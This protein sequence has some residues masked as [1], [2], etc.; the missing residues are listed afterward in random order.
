[1][2]ND[3]KQTILIDGVGYRSYTNWIKRGKPE[4]KRQYHIH[5]KEAVESIYSRKDGIFGAEKMDSIKDIK[6]LQ[7]KSF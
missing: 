4:Y 5:A 1:M 2:G 7:Y 3:A 6:R